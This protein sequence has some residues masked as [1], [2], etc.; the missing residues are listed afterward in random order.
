MRDE[1]VVVEHALVGVPEI[2][3]DGFASRGGA[4]LP[5]GNVCFAAE[6]RGEVGHVALVFVE[7][8]VE[9]DGGIVFGRTA[10][11]A[12]AEAGVEAGFAHGAVAAD[13]SP[14]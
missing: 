10:E 4:M 13:R 7:E 14:R 11:W 9:A 1:V 8:A 5:F 2:F 6:E 3:V 12:E